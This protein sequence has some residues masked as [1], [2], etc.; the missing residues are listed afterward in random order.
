MSTATTPINGSVAPE[1]MRKV[2]D[3]QRAAE[4]AGRNLY[5]AFKGSIATQAR[6]AGG[7]I[8][9]MLDR[10]GIR[11]AIARSWEFAS[12]WLSKAGGIASRI[13]ILPS[14]AFAATTHRG[15]HML[16]SAVPE[17]LYRIAMYPVKQAGRALMWA[18]EKVGYGRYALSAANHFTA[19]E[20]WALER[21]QTVIDWLNDKHSSFGMRAVRNG[22]F[23][24]LG[25]RVIAFIPYLPLQVLA[26]GALALIPTTEV[27]GNPG[28]LYMDSIAYLAFDA[29][30]TVFGGK[31]GVPEQISS[32]NRA[33]K[34]SDLAR[35][36]GAQ[37][38]SDAK[39]AGANRVEAR[40]IGRMTRQH[41]METGS[42]VPAPGQAPVL[43]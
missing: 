11:R 43:A 9:R 16:L 27:V 8:S 4:A 25:L 37:A 14:L 42:I 10:F 38:E 7:F 26:F 3:D 2:V 39:A 30:M 28:E 41:V 22:L 33:P 36:A 31:A 34:P 35:M 15:R 32:A 6:R 5:Q 19:F 1:T 40:R 13:G 24:V 20:V 17:R 23:M 12:P 29:V 18:A 21:Y